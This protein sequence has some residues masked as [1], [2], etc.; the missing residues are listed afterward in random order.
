MRARCEVHQ[1]DHQGDPDGVVEPRLT[2]E[3]RCGATFDLLPGED[4]ERDCRIRGCKGRPDQPGDGPVEVEDDV[5]G[6]CG[7]RCRPE[8]AGNAEHADRSGGRT[9]SRE[10]HAHAAV[11]QDRDEGE[12]GDALNVLE[13]QQ[14]GETIGKI[15]CDRRH[16]QQQGSRRQADPAREHANEDG[17]R[18]RARRDGDDAG[19]V[20]E[21]VH[22]LD[23]PR[24]GGGTWGTA[25][26]RANT[27]LT[28]VSLPAHAVSR[29]CSS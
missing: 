1:A 2:L 25:R 4:R 5:G 26:R 6:E 12:R 20:D 8:R 29:Y 15:R 22:A 27:F 19:E 3:N 13:G 9:K 17:D 24:F 18:E 23:S 10:P 21:V 16:D 11:E 28:R 14:G 7:E